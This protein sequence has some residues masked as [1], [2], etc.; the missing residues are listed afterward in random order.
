MASTHH[1]I[2]ASR[3]EGT[4]VFSA[5][6]EKLGKVDD[7][8]IEK[9]SGKAVYALMSFDG[10]LG[11]GARYFPVP[12]SLLDY[13]EDKGGYLTPLTREQIENG[14]SVGD[15]EV[16]DEVAWREQ[17]HAYYNVAPYWAAAAGTA[18]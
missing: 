1:L 4:P 16:E 11:A 2:A 8:L 3:V 13:D 14:H 9:V 7:L 18:Y 10:F 17:V 12:W 5:K 6:G 15:R